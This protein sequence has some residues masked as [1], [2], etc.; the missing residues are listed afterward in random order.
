[1]V[2]WAG[3]NEIDEAYAWSGLSI[4]P[5][6]DRLSRQVLPEGVR[7]L[8]PLPPPP[9]SS[10]YRSPEYVRRQ[11]QIDTLP[12]PFNAQPEQHL[13]GPRDDFKGPFYTRSLAHFA[14]EIG[15][16]GCPDR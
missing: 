9:P 1:L 8:D 15:Y 4:D 2:L 12:E 14:S 13:W 3:N 6:T 11:K 5:N 16:H 10:P 7:R